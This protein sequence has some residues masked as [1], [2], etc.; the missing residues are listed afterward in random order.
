MKVKCIKNDPLGWI[1]VGKTYEA[2]EVGQNIIIEG[3][4][5]ALSGKQFAEMFTTI[6]CA[7]Q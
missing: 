6:G 1:E 5:F 7:S 4:G 3:T 2:R